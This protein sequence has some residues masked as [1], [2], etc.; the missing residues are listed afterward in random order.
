MTAGRVVRI[1]CDWEPACSS[2]LYGHDG[3]NIVM[4]RER[5]DRDL[6]WAQVHPAR[7]RVQDYCPNHD[8]KA[9]AP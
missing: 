7:G 1:H 4:L 2:V 8:R 5:A 6:G 3:E 9:A